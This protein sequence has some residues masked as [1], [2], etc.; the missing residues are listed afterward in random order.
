MSRRALIAGFIIVIAIVVILAITLYRTG[1]T[2]QTTSVPKQAQAAVKYPI[3]VTDAL[4]RNVTFYK[5]PSRVIA[6]TTD[7][8]AYLTS[9]G[10]C[11]KIIGVDE[12]TMYEMKIL[13]IT[14]YA[15]CPTN[16]TAIGENI[17]VA[18]GWNESSILLLHPDLV[19]FANWAPKYWKGIE[20][21]E[22]YGI[23]VFYTPYYAASPQ[24]YFNT[25]I[26]FGE[27]FNVTS[28]AYELVEMINESIN[29]YSGRYNET[30]VIIDTYSLIAYKGQKFWL[31][32]SN[33]F[34]GLL[35]RLAGGVVL[36]NGSGYYTPDWLVATDPDVIIMFYMGLGN[37]NDAFQALAAMP[38]INMTKAWRNGRVYFIGPV[39]VDLMFYNP[40]TGFMY[41]LP[42]I[43]DILA[44]TAP[45][46][47]TASWIVHNYNYTYPVVG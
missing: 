2:K 4:E 41:G 7:A 21:L 6:Y 25:I 38:G 37:C 17:M 33:T 13:N 15:H 28:R 40:V 47:I 31:S 12:Y 1:T 10:L 3:T 44:G 35:V 42:V 5:P 46:C 45:R 34:E 23:Q 14:E 27:I 39:A 30:V 19:I 29:R 16:I 26:E 24:A 32:G 43:H 36:P 9:L 11:D 18:S 20:N 8:M 22:N